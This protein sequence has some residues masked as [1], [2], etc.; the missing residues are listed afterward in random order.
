LRDQDVDIG[1]LDI[2]YPSA[3]SAAATLVLFEEAKIGDDRLVDLL[4]QVDRVLLPDASL[5]D[6]SLRFTIVRGRAVG[7]FLP[8][9]E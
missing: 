6:K 7:T 5:T 8:V 4:E 2:H 9:E 1:L 3:T